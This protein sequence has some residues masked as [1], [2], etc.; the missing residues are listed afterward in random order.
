MEYIIPIEEILR[1]DV[2]QL[3]LGLTQ[4]VLIAGMF[5]SKFKHQKMFF[6]I[7]IP[8]LTSLLI[9]FFEIYV[10]SAIGCSITFILMTVLTLKF[11]KDPV[12]RKVLFGGWVVIILAFNITILSYVACGGFGYELKDDMLEIKLIKFF[13]IRDYVQLTNSEVM[14]T[15]DEVWKP[16]MRIY[17]YAYPGLLMGY[18]KLNNGVKAV[19]FKHKDSD[20]FVVINS[21]GKYYVIIHPGV[22]RLYEEIIKVKHEGRI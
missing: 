1:V 2:S 5:K 22:E 13:P 6:L 20:K 10:W 17:G 18:Y 15:S 21:S 8:V 14:L 4:A 11:H 16:K 19:L 7:M 3:I 9:I 12:A